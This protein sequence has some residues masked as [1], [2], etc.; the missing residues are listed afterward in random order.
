MVVPEPSAGPYLLVPLT[1]QKTLSALFDFFLQFRNSVRIKK[2]FELKK[3]LNPG[4]A[5]L[6]VFHQLGPTGPSWS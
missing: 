6:D 4:C 2:M 1:K 5:K 3:I